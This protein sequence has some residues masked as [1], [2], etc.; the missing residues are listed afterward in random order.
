MTEFPTLRIIHFAWEARNFGR[1]AAGPARISFELVQHLRKK[2]MR[3][4]LVIPFHGPQDKIKD[5]NEVRRLSGTVQ[6]AGVK[7]PFDVYMTERIGS[8]PVYA[9][10]HRLLYDR[11]T[12]PYQGTG[13][14][15]RFYIFAIAAMRIINQLKP[16]VVVCHDYSTALI[17]LLMINGDRCRQ[18]PFRVLPTVHQE[19]VY[20]VSR[21]EELLADSPTDIN[22]GLFH[23]LYDPKNEGW[24][25]IERLEELAGAMLPALH[26][27]GLTNNGWISLLQLIRRMLRSHWPTYRGF[28]VNQY[29]TLTDQPLKEA[30]R[31]LSLREIEQYRYVVPYFF[32]GVKPIE[33]TVLPDL[34]IQP[35]V[36]T[37]E[38]IL[39]QINPFLAR[40]I[41]SGEGLIG[42]D[43]R[44]L[45]YEFVRIGQG[46]VFRNISE[47][48]AG[49]L[50]R[51][52]Q[53]IKNWN[54]LDP[55]GSLKGFQTFTRQVS[56]GEF[57]RVVF[58]RGEGL[59]RPETIPRLPPEEQPAFKLLVKLGRAA[60]NRVVRFTLAESSGHT[61][62]GRIADEHDNVGLYGVKRLKGKT[63][64]ELQA[65]D[66]LL[67]RQEFGVEIPWYIMI[68]EGEKGEEVKRYVQQ[69]I[70]QGYT[71]DPANFL[72]PNLVHYFSHLGRLPA[73]DQ[74]GNLLLEEIEGERTLV[75]TAQGHGQFLYT[76][77]EQ[78]QSLVG[79]GRDLAFV[80][81]I[82]N[83]GAQISTNEFLAILGHFILNETQPAM[84]AEMVWP[85]EVRNGQAAKLGLPVFIGGEQRLASSFELL[86]GQPEEDGG[87]PVF[88]NT[89]LLNLNRMV[90]KKREELLPPPSIKPLHL[91]G[92]RPRDHFKLHFKLTYCL[93]HLST[94]FSTGLLL[95][96]GGR[97]QHVGMFDEVDPNTG[98]DSLRNSQSPG[99]NG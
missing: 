10:A 90:R 43:G 59:L 70:C 40:S 35:L 3:P 57:G 24:V 27:D 19:L 56:A 72:N 85:R 51:D 6:M 63:M 53:R 61:F 81:G 23:Y 28:E 89:L 17:P 54:P 25:P 33:A 26:L 22:W 68:G 41:A 93:E 9:V 2:E 91:T 44:D 80:S 78:L 76:L 7:E 88:I 99:E 73:V 48:K 47:R 42:P 64:L 69:G 11:E 60:L 82:R 14:L 21:G 13:Q 46:E 55:D 79:S 39:S 18:N 66:L 86:N 95:V 52:L 36:L 32:P 8:V 30:V 20:S 62:L 4:Y 12:D 84:Q 74:N 38:E 5:F 77:G 75:M 67:A 83:L 15:E 94:Y 37:P 97:Y 1:E 45:I 65:S 98:R 29:A 96:P 16:N 92:D 58:K 31:E 49:P 87:V 71:T 50:L 34:A